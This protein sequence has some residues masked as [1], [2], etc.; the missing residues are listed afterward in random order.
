MTQLEDEIKKQQDE[1]KARID[2]DWA[3]FVANHPEAQVDQSLNEDDQLRAKCRIMAEAQR[4]DPKFLAAR[5]LTEAYAN[6]QAIA[7][8]VAAGACCPQCGGTRLVWECCDLEAVE[9]MKIT[10][11]AWKALN[12]TGKG[13]WSCASA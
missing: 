9:A 12:K 11:T 10:E 8:G 2:E 5:K 13:A 4:N 1:S 7:I 6:H 3:A